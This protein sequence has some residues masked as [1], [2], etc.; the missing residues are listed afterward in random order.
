MVMCGSATGGGY[1]TDLNYDSHN[2][3][4][5]GNAC[6]AGSECRNA[7]CVPINPPGCQPPLMT[8]I[9]PTGS[10][11]CTD[12]NYDSHNCGG[13]YKVCAP[14]SVWQRGHRPPPPP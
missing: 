9:S 13:C 3:G 8:C 1:C 2:C 11:F 14:R 4:H 6:A 10:S 7:Q 5:C 12:P